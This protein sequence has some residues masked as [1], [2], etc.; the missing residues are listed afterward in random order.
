MLGQSAAG[1]LAAGLWPGCLAAD[2]SG[3]SVDFHFIA[4]NDFH[5]LD[6]QCGPWFDHALKQM[7]GHKEKIDF[8]LLLGDLAENGTQEQLGAVHDILKSVKLPV[9]VVVGNH[10]YLTN[11]DRKPFERLYPKF[12]N[13]DFEHKGWQFIGL[14][15]TQGLAARNTAI[16][17][18]T[19]QWLEGRLTKLDKEKPTVVF[20]HFPLGTLVPGRPKNAEAL[21]DRFKEFNLQAVL[22]G[23]FH[24]ITTRKSNKTVLTTN[25]CCSFRRQNHDGAKEKGYLLCHAREGAIER[26]F[27]EVKMS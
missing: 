15:T 24:G 3:H 22:S 27:V 4:V 19:L 2:E 26:K 14:D 25:A 18:V 1:L 17:P 9:H 7:T 6:K 10:D 23:H 13:Y 11:T 16:Q 12:I 21:L 8:I 20:T 5:Y